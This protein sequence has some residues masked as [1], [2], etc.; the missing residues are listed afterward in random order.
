MRMSSLF[1]LGL[2]SLSSS[3]PSPRGTSARRREQRVTEQE[4]GI[5][6][7]L[8]YGLRKGRQQVRAEPLDELRGRSERF[9]D[10]RN[11]LAEHL[12][13]QR[14]LD[15]LEQVIDAVDDHGRIAQHL[16][17][18]GGFREEAPNSGSAITISLESPLR[19]FAK[20][21]MTTRECS[22]RR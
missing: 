16:E 15:R 17:D 14:V 18:A 2:P 19:N 9:A 12:A 10:Q 13:V 1:A 8:A 5:A 3:R 6:D 20:L 21:G 11:L 7:R 4:H 22:D